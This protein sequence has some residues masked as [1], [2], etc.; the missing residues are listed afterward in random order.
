LKER[1]LDR[2]QIEDLILVKGYPTRKWLVEPDAGDELVF[3]G[4]SL[5]WTQVQ[6]AAGLASR[7][8]RSARSQ[9]QRKGKEVAQEKG[10]GKG[11]KKVQTSW[12]TTILEEEEDVDSEE[13]REEGFYVEEEDD[14]DDDGLASLSDS[15]GL[16]AGRRPRVAT[17]DET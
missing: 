9:T 3:K 10:K 17:D 1:H 4:E 6:E 14:S 16:Y 13:T 7:P 15:G 2:F 11:K 5:T 12:R 8:L